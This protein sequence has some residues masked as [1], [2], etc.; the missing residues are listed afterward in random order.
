MIYLIGALRQY[1][2]TFY[3]PNLRMFSIKLVGLM[4]ASRTELMRV[5]N[6]SG[7]PLKRRLL[8]S[9]E[10]IRLGWKDIYGTSTLA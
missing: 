10:N 9:P 3:D 2:K 4:F 7:A 6:T 1:L 8:A 5:E